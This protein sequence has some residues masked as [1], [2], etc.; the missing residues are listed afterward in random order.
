MEMLSRQWPL[1]QTGDRLAHAVHDNEDVCS[2]FS[3]RVDGDRLSALHPHAGQRSLIA[4][5]GAGD[6]ADIHVL[7]I[8]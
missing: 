2:R 8:L 1:V 6:V 3:R 5:L 7:T 4:Q